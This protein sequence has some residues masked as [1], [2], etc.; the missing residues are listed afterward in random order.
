MEYNDILREASSEIAIANGNIYLDKFV[1]KRVNYNHNRLHPNK[2]GRTRK[3]NSAYVFQDGK[4]VSRL[5]Q[6]NIL[7][8]GTQPKTLLPNYRIFDEER[9]FFSMQDI[10]KDFSVPLESLLQPF[11]LKIDGKQMHIGF[12]LCEDLWCE[13]YRRNGEALNPT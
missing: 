7:P 12:E 3:Y 11:L 2:D 8:L 4:P 10:A 5:K 9:Y 6:T 1:E 13:D